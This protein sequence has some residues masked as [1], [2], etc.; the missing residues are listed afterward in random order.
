MEPPR[1]PPTNQEFDISSEPAT[2][3]EVEKAIKSLKNNK[4]AGPDNIPAEVLKAHINTSV[5]MAF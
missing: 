1:L 2:R 4:A 5:N 3:V